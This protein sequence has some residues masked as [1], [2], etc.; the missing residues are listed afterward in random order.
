[1]KSGVSRFSSMGDVIENWDPETEMPVRRMMTKRTGRDRI[2]P[3]R[4]GCDPQYFMEYSPYRRYIDRRAREMKDFVCSRDDIKIAAIDPPEERR[5]TITSWLCE[6]CH[7]FGSKFIAE[8][9]TECRVVWCHH[10]KTETWHHPI[11]KT[12]RRDRRYGSTSALRT[13]TQSD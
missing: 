11:M 2:V 4:E 3:I 5:T 10:C 6:W 7:N 8:H 13:F 9:P 12:D 1:M